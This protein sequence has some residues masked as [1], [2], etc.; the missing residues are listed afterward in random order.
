MRK[1]FLTIIFLL[2]TFALNALEVSESFTYSNAF[3]QNSVYVSQDLNYLVNLGFNFDLTEYENIENHIYTFSL[4]LVLKTENFVLLLRPFIIPDNANEASA[5]GAKTSFSFTIKKDEVDNSFADVFFALGFA[6][7]DAYVN[8]TGLSANK[9]KFNQL[10]Y[11]GGISLNYFNA[12]FFEISGNMFE[13]LSGIS[14][15]ESIAG[16]LDQ[17]NIASLDTLNYVLN[18][19]K[20]SIGAKIRWNSQVSQSITTISYRF[21]EFQD[22]DISAQHSALFSTMIMMKNNFY[23]NLAYNHIFIESQKD[24]DI[25][26]GSISFKF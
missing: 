5:F 24:K 20:G 11:E 19:P 6:S 18:L 13:Y 1:I 14:S 22:K 9:E 10:A 17:Q 4:P 21:I 3:W 12:Y 25:F 7:Q 16:V 15:V 8:K 26:K 2:G 23:I